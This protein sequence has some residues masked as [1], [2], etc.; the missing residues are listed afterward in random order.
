MPYAT[1]TNLENLFGTEQV[2]RWSQLDQSLTTTDAT[3]VAA[4]IAYADAQI[5]TALAGGP[6]TVPLALGTTGNIIVSTWSATLA[7]EWLAGNRGAREDEEGIPYVTEK[8]DEVRAQIARVKGGAIR[9]DAARANSP[10]P[11]APVAV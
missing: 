11:Q 1:Q 10:M 5:D 7:A 4:A 8:A 6:Y 9:L 3:R 2:A